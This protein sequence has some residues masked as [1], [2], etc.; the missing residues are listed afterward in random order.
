MEDMHVCHLAFCSLN[1]EL[2]CYSR[3]QSI[4][5]E[6]PAV[7]EYVTCTWTICMTLCN[8]LVQNTRQTFSSWPDF[9]HYLTVHPNT[10]HSPL[11][12]V[13]HYLSCNRFA[14][15]VTANVLRPS[16]PTDI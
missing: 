5:F 11:I 14:H 12:N 9:P 7:Q 8:T 3:E 2:F 10:S 13:R 1:Q 16:K 4:L 6:L 15:L